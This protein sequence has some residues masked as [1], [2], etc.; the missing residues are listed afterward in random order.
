MKN[1]LIFTSVILYEILKY[2]SFKKIL[3]LKL[4][5]KQFNEFITKKY[6]WKIKDPSYNPKTDYVHMFNAVIYSLLHLN[7]YE[8]KN[9]ISYNSYYSN[10]YCFMYLKR[11]I[12]YINNTHYINFNLAEKKFQN[13]IVPVIK[14]LNLN[15]SAA[16]S[17]KNI[18]NIKYFIKN[19]KNNFINMF[20]CFTS[21]SFLV[22]ISDYCF[23]NNAIWAQNDACS[24]D[25]FQYYKPIINFHIPNL[26]KIMIYLINFHIC[27]NYNFD[28]VKFK[29]T[30]MNKNTPIAK[31]VT[32]T[33]KNKFR[34]LSEGLYFMNKTD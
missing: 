13:H 21:S 16:K 11:K 3:N 33:D 9:N 26:K 2:F 19:N 7:L 8:P 29:V 14:F 10:T 31:L 5:S 34:K 17:D 32:Y 6:T 20:L 4:V 28:V 27:N 1:I 23:K 30:N 15:N 18:E 22:M 25:Y 24:C 12:L